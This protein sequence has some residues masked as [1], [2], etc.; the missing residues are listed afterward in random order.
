M[1]RQWWLIRWYRFSRNIWQILGIATVFTAAVTLCWRMNW[2]R[3]HAS[4]LKAYDQ[5]LEAF[6][7]RADKSERVAVIA[8]DD[9]TLQFID[10]YTNDQGQHEL[11]DRYGKWPYYRGIWADL[12]EYLKVQGARAVIFDL[13][14]DT[15]AEDGGDL[16]LRAAIEAT[17]L[18]VYL[19]FA[20]QKPTHPPAERPKVEARNL[21]PGEAIPPAPALPPPP[22]GVV[23]AE[24]FAIDSEVA[25]DPAA[26]RA[27]E[28]ALLRW[29][30]ER[31]AFPVQGDALPTLEQTYTDLSGHREKL[32]REPLPPAPELLGAVSGAGLVEPEQDPDGVIRRTRFAYTDGTNRYVTLPIAAAADLLGA[33]EV[34]LGDGVLRLGAR[35]FEVNRDGSA[36]IDFGGPLAERFDHYSLI[37]ALIDHFSPDGPRHIP[38]GAF[39]DKVVV[40][41]GFAVA[42]QDAK[43]TPFASLDPGCVKQA[44]VLDALL[45]GRFIVDAPLWLAIAVTF[46]IAF[47]S[48]AIGKIFRNLFVNVGWPIVLYAG[49]F[50]VSGL[51]LR[52]WHVHLPAA[53][54]VW[55]GIPASLTSVAFARLFA[56]R[57]REKLK[58]SF[59]RYL[60]R[61]LVEQLDVSNELPRLEGEIREITAFFSDIRGFSTFSEGL[62]R[63]PEK[64]VRVLNTYLTRVS[65]VLVREGGCLDKYIGD[66]VVCLFGAPLRQSDHAV[67]A[68]RAALAAQAEVARLREEFRKEGLP[69]VYTRIGLNSGEMLVGN[70]GSEQ[71]F[72]YT[73]MGDD[74]N[75]AS[76]LE[77]ANKAYGTSIMIG[78]RTRELAKDF[79]EVRELDRVRV[80]GKREAVVVYELLALK[81]ELSETKRTVVRLYEEAL[82]QYRARQFDEALVTLAK[83]EAIDPDDGPAHTLRQRCE[84]YRGALPPDFDG[85]ANLEK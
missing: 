26:Q 42:T 50:V 57:K 12:L 66:A 18:P 23:P 77:G 9:Q 73:A 81:G 31:V 68:C 52:H 19:G 37:A 74:M 85:V 11:R 84:K 33:R 53:M 13:V 40:V 22:D 72:D 54:P 71:L 8:V 24:A 59:V 62:K 55:A 32:M 29:S 27:H 2:L 39:R 76:R 15:T 47:L 45:G 7:R 16:R 67:R 51:V 34:A 82:A 43:A 61:T 83:L 4:E 1:T 65:A 21:L 69:D 6:T 80:A 48:A 56:D 79:I 63:E 14:M 49:F 38:E 60:D 20:L 58:A 25:P 3:I 75:L 78:A 10:G 64:L 46:L 35:R 41:G 36:L 28:A 30:Y 5:A 70:F 17:R 44:A